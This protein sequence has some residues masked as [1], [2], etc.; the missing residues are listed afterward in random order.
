M[1]L[2]RLFVSL[3]A[4]L[5]ACASVQPAVPPSVPP[6][7]PTLLGVLRVDFPGWAIPRRT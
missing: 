4:L 3:V 6:S 7:A 1:N 2:L 5:G